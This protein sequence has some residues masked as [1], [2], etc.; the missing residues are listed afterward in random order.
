MRQLSTVCY[1]GQGR[2]ATI[3]FGYFFSRSW[4]AAFVV[5]ISSM[6]LMADATGV[7]FHGLARAKAAAHALRG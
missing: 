6:Q 3:L 5:L 1:G 2:C 4:R 7:W